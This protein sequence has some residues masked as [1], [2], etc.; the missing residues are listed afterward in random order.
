LSKH[1]SIEAKLSG[2][3]EQNSGFFRVKD[4]SVKL[5]PGNQDSNTESDGDAREE[6]REVHKTHFSF[7][8]KAMNPTFTLDDEVLLNAVVD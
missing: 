3:D 2:I 1:Q 7:Q 5:V 8:D 6:I 4:N